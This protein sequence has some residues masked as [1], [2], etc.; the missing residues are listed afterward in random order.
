[1]N[2]QNLAQI[3]DH[4]IARF[5]ELNNPKNSEYY[6]W[7]IAAQFRPMLDEALAASNAD[8]PAKLAAV[9]LMTS[10]TIDNPYERAFYALSDYAK[11]EP[12]P[13]RSAIKNLLVPDGGD[14]VLRKQHFTGFLDFCDTMHD[15]YFPDSWLYRASIRLPMMITGFYDP[16]HYYLYKASQAKAYADCADFYDN[17]GS[18]VNIDLRI[19]HR[20]CDELV[21]AIKTNDELLR[22]NQERYGLSQKPMHPDAEYHL[23]AF[24]IIF[25]S[26]VYNL[27]DGIHFSTKSA[28]E[29]KKYHENVKAANDLAAKYM[30]T[31]ERAEKLDAAEAFFTQK[32]LTGGNIKHKVFGNGTIINIQNTDTVEAK[33]PEKKESVRLLWRDCISSGLISFKTE[34]NAAEYDDMAALINANTARM[35]R[36]NVAVAEEKLAPYTEYLQ[37]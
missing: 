18:G 6:K 3:F 30:E 9:V 28:E 23:L 24:D 11:K 14:L 27:Y 21:E 34:E 17:W 4:Y 26:T 5:N 7:E 20:M 16:D 37:D 1:M 15:K 35:I 2:N 36:S 12:E 8:L 19:Y 31:L 29:K 32:L 13:V 33:F 22:V 25:C 10:N